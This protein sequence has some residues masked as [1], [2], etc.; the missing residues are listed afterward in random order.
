MKASFIYHTIALLFILSNNICSQSDPCGCD[1][2]LV[3]GVYNY[4]SAKG[5]IQSLDVV[6]SYI[7][8]TSYEDFMKNKAN[9]LGGS[10]KLLSIDSGSSKSQ[11]ESKKQEFRQQG[12]SGSEY[13]ES[14]DILEKYGDENVL[15]AWSKCRSD[16]ITNGG[17][18]YLVSVDDQ[19]NGSVTLVYQPKAGSTDP[20]VTESHIANAKS[21]RGDDRTETAVPQGYTLPIG[22]TIISFRRKNS[23]EPVIIDLAITGGRDIHIFV[24]EYI[25][26]TPDELSCEAIQNIMYSKGVFNVVCNENTEDGY[27]WEVDIEERIRPYGEYMLG[28][29][30]ICPCDAASLNKKAETFSWKNNAHRLVYWFPVRTHYWRLQEGGQLVEGNE[31]PIN[32]TPSDHSRHEYV[33]VYSVTCKRFISE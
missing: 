21:T 27:Y 24:P 12:Y 14:N 1:A 7:V 26:P 31:G 25:E 28:G 19:I 18:V 32:D 30:D 3:D 22:K 15:K 33:G 10:Y 9:S 2:V 16:C 11:Y 17:L 20:V 4:R 6:K 13:Q 5:D 29:S 8:R 23:D